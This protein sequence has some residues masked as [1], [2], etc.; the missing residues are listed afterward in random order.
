MAS[1]SLNNNVISII[2]Q[3]DPNILLLNYK[4]EQYNKILSS[5]NKMTKQCLKFTQDS[6]INNDLIENLRNL[7]F[8][9]E[10]CASLF[11]EKII[12]INI[13]KSNLK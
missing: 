12:H 3:V 1:K 7:A 6:Y 4:E 9:I 8:N 5:L 11:D 13:V 2:N 10:K